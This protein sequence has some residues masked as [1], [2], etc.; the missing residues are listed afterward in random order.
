MYYVKIGTA[1]VR[2][3]CDRAEIKD[4]VNKFSEENIFAIVYVT[5]EL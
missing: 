1:A 5:N 2:G 3:R 4:E